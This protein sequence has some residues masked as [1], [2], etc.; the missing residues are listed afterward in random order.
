MQADGYARNG[1]PD[2]IGPVVSGAAYRPLARSG[3][4]MTGGCVRV[5]ELKKETYSSIF[6]N[7]CHF[8]GPAMFNV[9][10]SRSPTSP[11]RATESTSQASARPSASEVDSKSSPTGSDAKSLRERS[12]EPAQALSVRVHLPVEIPSAI[13][14]VD[15]P[16]ALGLIEAEESGE[17]EAS[18]QELLEQF[19]ELERDHL[20]G[21]DRRSAQLALRHGEWAIALEGLEAAVAV[22]PGVFGPESL[23]L[24]TA[25]RNA[26]SQ[27]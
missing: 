21:P 11:V 9:F 2:M 1:Q 10:A 17:D 15:S 16:H 24:L 5:F 26:M 8:L 18:T 3:T 22:E 12:V 7:N 14:R 23:A 13:V 19:M 25:A 27:Q 4:R 6:I 20:A